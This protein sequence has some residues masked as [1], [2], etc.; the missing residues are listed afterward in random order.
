M[1]RRMLPAVSER[2]HPAR[3]M[4]RPAFTVVLA[5]PLPAVMLSP[6]TGG[7]APPSYCVSWH[8]WTSRATEPAGTA[9][10][11][12]R[13]IEQFHGIS[14]SAKVPAD[15]VCPL[16]PIVASMAL[17]CAVLVPVGSTMIKLRRHGHRPP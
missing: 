15:K 2:V 5:G 11:V 7:V 10:A 8:I 12:H 4:S 1:N 16:R 6:D 17:F 3:I 9:T 14:T 13:A